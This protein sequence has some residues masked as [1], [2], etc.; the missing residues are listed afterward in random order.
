MR[1]SMAPT[2]TCASCIFALYDANM[3]IGHVRDFVCAVELCRAGYLGNPYH[4]GVFPDESYNAMLAAVGA[5]AHTSV[6]ESRVLATCM[7]ASRKRKW[8]PK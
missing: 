7:Q 3:Q 6:W 8:Q 1:N 4:Y 2:R 5:H